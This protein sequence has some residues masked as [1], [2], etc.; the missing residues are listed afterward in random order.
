MRSI[1]FGFKKAAKKVQIVSLLA[2]TLLGMSTMALQ[3]K[4]SAA[5]TF[6]GPFNC[7]ANSVIWCGAKDTSVIQSEYT[8]G[9][10]HNS[11]KSIQAIYDYFGISESDIDSLGVT[12][13]A[14]S[15]TKSGDVYAGNTLVAT[16]AWTAGREYISGS[17]TVTHDGVTFYKRQPKVSFLDNS[18]TAYVVMQNG[19]FKFA[20]LSACGNPVIAVPKTPSKG[21]LACTQLLTTPITLESN[22]DQVVTFTAKASATNATIDNYIFDLGSGHGKQTVTTSATSVTTDKQTYKPGTYTISATVNGDAKNI[23]TTA[24]SP[25]TCSTK[26]TVV[27]PTCTAPNGHQYPKGSP[28]CVVCQYNSQLSANS[29]ECVPPTTPPTTPPT[30]P[31]TGAGNVIGLFF[32]AS[33]LGGVAYH[34]FIKRRLVRL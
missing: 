32:G 25:D 12:A 24:P 34:Y 20:I 13:V 1:S 6:G 11:A 33:S 22:G 17:T 27:P 19:Q 30:L 29:S 14:G 21:E 26:L 2:I 16:G 7:D 8:N 5:V 18:L 23:F 4:V 9:D 28:N 31:N 3:P 10:G 15:V